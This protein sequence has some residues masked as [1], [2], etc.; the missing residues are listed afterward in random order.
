MIHG[1]TMQ[2]GCNSILL[3]IWFIKLDEFLNL[4]NKDQLFIDT[5]PYIDNFRN[6]SLSPALHIPIRPIII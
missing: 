6:I 5:W 2:F 3:D 4:L 1:A